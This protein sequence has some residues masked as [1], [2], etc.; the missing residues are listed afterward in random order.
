MQFCKNKLKN[1]PMFSITIH[2][3][4]HIPLFTH[5]IVDRSIQKSLKYHHKN[6]YYDEHKLSKILAWKTG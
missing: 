2:I 6:K 4:D 3:N 5:K 1:I